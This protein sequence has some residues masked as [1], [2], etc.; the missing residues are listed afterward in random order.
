[1]N[2]KGFNYI[3]SEPEQYQFLES[4]LKEKFKQHKEDS[5]LLVEER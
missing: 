5:K 2:A 4:F 3:L 1:M